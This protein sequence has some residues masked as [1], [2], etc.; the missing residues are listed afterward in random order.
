MIALAIVLALLPPAVYPWPI[1]AGPRYRPA[2]APSAV[3]AGQPV[4]ALRCGP[5]ATRFSVHL[6]LFANRRAIVIPAGIGVASPYRRAG[7][8]VRPEGCVYPVHT[9]EP[10]G[11][12]R[13]GLRDATLGDLFRVWGQGIGRRR[14]LSFGSHTR[15]R[16]F[17]NG[18]E[19][20]G[21]PR[22]TPLTHHDQ[23]VLE[24][25][26]YVPP[27]TSYLFPKGAP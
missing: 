25:R 16:A 3:R 21:D 9:T 1:G 20:L 19:R 7:A 23:V 27:H 22:N 11:V 5:D 18:V 10:T 6:E 4:G 14:L 13:V 17:V 2:A 12:I 24:I 8:D 26:G 15:V